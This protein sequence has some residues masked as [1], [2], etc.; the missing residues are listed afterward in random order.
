MFCIVCLTAKVEKQL[1]MAQI[2]GALF[3][4]LMTAVFVGTSLQIQKD[5]ILSPHSIFLF[6]VI[7]SFL[8][9]AILHPLE[10]TCVIPGIL[11]FLAIP[12]MYML[13]PIYSICNLNTVSWGTR[14]DPRPQEKNDLAKVRKRQ[15]L[16]LVENGTETEVDGDWS[17]GC[18]SACRLLCCLKPDKLESS[19]QIWRINEKLSE[20]NRKLERIERKQ[21]HGLVRRPSV[22]STGGGSV[23]MHK[24][25]EDDEQATFECDGK[26]MLP[27]QLMM[28]C[29]TRRSWLDDKALRRAD[30]EVLDPDEEHFWLDVIEKYLSP[31]T[32]DPKEQ[33]RV[34]AAL[35]ELRNKV[36]STFLMVN[37]VFIIII[38]VLQL[39]KDCLHIE[40]PIGPKFNHSVRLCNGDNKKEVWIVTRLQLEPLGL[41]FL[42]FFMSILIIQFIA[43]LCHRFGTL[44]HI[45]ASTELF[46]CRK[47]VGK[48]SEDELVVQNAVEIARELQAI[49]GVDEGNHED[50]GEQIGHRRVVH[51]LE[52]F[53]LSLMK[54][55]TET[56]DAAFKKRFFALSSEKNEDSFIPRDSRRRLTLTKGTIKAL[57]N[58]RDSLYGAFEKMNHPPE[59]IIRGSPIAINRGPA[60]RRLEKIF[61]NPADAREIE[62]PWPVQHVWEKPD[63][64]LRRF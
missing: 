17:I 31:L 59:V 42:I 30:P 62:K 27:R 11:Y 32:L 43:M 64:D 38:L 29:V 3:A 63:L 47:T 34:R 2:V 28:K 50:R 46:C 20:I 61:N 40:W 53:R 52:S 26:L 49:R 51:N 4:M 13:L 44:A 56:L 14:E 45:I 33:E 15:H 5:G 37:I 8:T 22:L 39:Q 10:F 12:C 1:L 57:E 7:G 9:A 16:D 24:E 60:Q 18:G 54:R 25:M 48:L 21:Q 19:P 55:R 58:R 41:V 6:S 23:D 36:V 35:I